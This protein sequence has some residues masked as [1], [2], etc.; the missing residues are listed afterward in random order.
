MTVVLFILLLSLVSLGNCQSLPQLEH[1]GLDL[2]NNSFIYFN[3]I[4]G[5]EDSALN[6]VT[7]SVNCCN[8]SDIG[9]WSDESGRPVYQ[10]ADG[11]TC[12]YV[13]RGDGVISLHR[14]RG[15]TDHTSGLWRCDIPDSSGKMHSLYAYIGHERY[16]KPPGKDTQ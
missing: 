9:G 4:G 13:T 1:D 11:T 15:C 7:E 12:L 16:S 5:D 3:D 10:G 8:N 14:K 2:S 6:C